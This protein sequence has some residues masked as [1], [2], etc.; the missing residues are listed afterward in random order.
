MMNRVE[1]GDTVRLYGMPG[2]FSVHPCPFSTYGDD[3]F[4][5]VSN[6][7]Q[8]SFPASDWSIVERNGKLL[9]R[10]VQ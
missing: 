1:F 3:Y 2:T 8:C 7:F 5:A 10:D 6:D 4:L 9:K